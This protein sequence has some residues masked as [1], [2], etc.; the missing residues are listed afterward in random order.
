MKISIVEDSPQKIEAVLNFFNEN[1]D[2]PDITVSES[3]QSGLKKIINTSPKLVVLDMTLP[4]FDKKAGI[5]EGRMRPLGGYDLLRKIRLKKINIQ[6]IVL[7]QLDYF[8]EGQDRVS[9][10]DVKNMCRNEFGSMFIEMI[11]YKHSNEVWKEELMVA[12]NKVKT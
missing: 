4:T 5:R 2:S 12:I 7:T 3:Y 11:R 6:V 1:Y 9:F 8:G 10:K